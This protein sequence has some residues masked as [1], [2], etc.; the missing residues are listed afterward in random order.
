MYCWRKVTL[1]IEST[2]VSVADEGCFILRPGVITAEDLEKVV[3]LFV[4]HNPNEQTIGSLSSPGLL[5]SHY[6]PTKPMYLL[7]NT[8][9]ILPR[10][11]VL[12]YIY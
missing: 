3:P 5:H 10:I 9:D 8:M 4:L 7:D 2:V 6:A 1:I 12:L 11:Q